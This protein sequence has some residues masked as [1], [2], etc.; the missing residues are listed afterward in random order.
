MKTRAEMAEQHGPDEGRDDDGP[1]S[2]GMDY[3]HAV[4][5]GLM[6]FGIEAETDTFVAD[7]IAGYEFD[8]IDPESAVDRIVSAVE[9]RVA[10]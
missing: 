7:L 3:W 2:I 1:T 10:D 4:R 8:G 6:A 5:D 9:D